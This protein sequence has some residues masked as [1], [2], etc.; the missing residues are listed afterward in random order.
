MSRQKV[1][2]IRSLEP[3]YQPCVVQHRIEK[4][5]PTHRKINSRSL[6]SPYLHGGTCFEVPSIETD[7]PPQSAQG[8]EA[9]C[10]RH[11]SWAR[12][13]TSTLAS[14]ASLSSVAVVHKHTAPPPPSLHHH[15]IQGNKH[16]GIA[17]SSLYRAA[18]SAPVVVRKHTTPPPFSTSTTTR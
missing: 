9:P 1:M 12:G 18:A 16:P 5:A 4:S 6:T 11:F 13:K 10:R 14:L 2:D 7:D 8:K 17:A 15:R 3:R